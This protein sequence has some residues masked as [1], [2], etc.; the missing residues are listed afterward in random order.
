MSTIP[1]RVGL[2]FGGASG[3]HAVSIRSAAT[4]A[5]ALRS[6]ANA[7]RYAL[8]CFYIDLQGR[9]WGSALADAV[10]AQGT[11]AT[12]EQLAGNPAPAG[13]RGFPP[14]ADQIAVWLPILHGPNGEDG[15]IQGLF[16]LMQVPFVGSGGLEI[17]RAH[18]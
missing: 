1:T 7:S 9:W 8:S 14:G 5:G 2:I 13:F 3:E 15:T 6:G 12:P 18:V 16:T 11:P 17:G 4:V 10:L